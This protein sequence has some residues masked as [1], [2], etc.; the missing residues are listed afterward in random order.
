M[1]GCQSIYSGQF[2]TTTQRKAERTGVTKGSR[3]SREHVPWYLLPGCMIDDGTTQ[4]TEMCVTERSC[5]RARDAERR[6]RLMPRIQIARVACIR[7]RSW[8]LVRF[9]FKHASGTVVACSCLHAYRGPV[10]V[11]PSSASRAPELGLAHATWSG[12]FRSMLV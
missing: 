12:Y 11:E 2:W 4:A 6:R 7:R 5:C 1:L 8:W 10:A 3:V 9:G